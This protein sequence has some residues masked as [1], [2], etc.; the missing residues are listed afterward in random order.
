[1]HTFS[2]RSYTDVCIRADAWREYIRACS[3][4][5]VTTYAHAHMHAAGRGDR[6]RRRLARPRQGTAHR[7]GCLVRVVNTHKTCKTYTNGCLVHVAHAHKTCKTHTHGA[8]LHTDIRVK[9]EGLLGFVYSA[10]RL[11]VERRYL[12]TG[13]DVWCMWCIHIRQTYK[14]KNAVER[15]YLHTGADACLVCLPFMCMAHAYSKTHAH[16]SLP[17]LYDTCI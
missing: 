10:F 8:A 6:P 7:Y 4:I 15:R 14:A 12:R 13:T 3:H 5:H 2:S 17:D 11:A 1:M 9:S 16:A